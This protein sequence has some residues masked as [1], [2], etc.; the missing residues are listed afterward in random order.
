MEYTYRTQ[1]ICPKE[2]VIKLDGSTVQDV[3]FKGGC[4][5]NLKAI[6]RVVQGMTVD[7]VKETFT[8]ITCG[9]RDT[10]CTDQLAKAVHE[11]FAEL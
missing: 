1:G 5:G 6:R 4:S 10:S 8:G 11:A 7:E 3:E 2:I 9:I